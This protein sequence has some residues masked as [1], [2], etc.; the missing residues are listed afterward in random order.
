MSWRP[1]AGGLRPHL[2]EILDPH[3]IERIWTPGGGGGEG[4]RSWNFNCYIICCSQVRLWCNTRCQKLGDISTPTPGYTHPPEG[5]VGQN[6]PPF[7]LGQTNTSENLPYHTSTSLTGSNKNQVVSLWG[8]KAGRLPKRIH[9]QWA[10]AKVKC[11][12]DVSRRY[13]SK[14]PKNSFF[15]CYRFCNLVCSTRSYP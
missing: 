14:F 11:F 15:G 6:Y 5:T 12:F 3:E 9:P 7:H 10:I 13:Y 8:S 1:L 4:S 2:G